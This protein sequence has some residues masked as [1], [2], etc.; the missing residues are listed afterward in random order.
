MRRAKTGRDFQSDGDV[1]DYVH[2]CSHTWIVEFEWSEPKREWVLRERGIDFIR[3]AAA[4]FDGRPLLTVSS[5]RGGE[6]RFLS[7]GLVEGRVFSV[8]WMWR[9]DAIRL[10]TARRARDEEEE[11]YHASFG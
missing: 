9:N 4:L 11:R 10:I 8:V 6:E 5:P 7:V 3:V 2:I 1:L